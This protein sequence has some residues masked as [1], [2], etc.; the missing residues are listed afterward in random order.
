V[1]RWPRTPAELLLA[2]EVVW[3]ATEMRF[4]SRRWDVKRLLA[5]QTP[6]PEPAVDDVD[7]TQAA[8]EL[9][10]AA[11]WTDRWLALFPANP[12]GSCYPRA[13]ALY[14]LAR[15]RGLPV[16]FVLGVSRSGDGVDGH[17]WLTLHGKPYLERGGEWRGHR[18]MFSYPKE[19]AP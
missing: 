17:A 16:R 6:V 12:K 4:L 8:R 19:Q 9:E 7:A 5:S 18:L 3:T 2:G 14:V 1:K 13:L 11:R 15:R 10:L